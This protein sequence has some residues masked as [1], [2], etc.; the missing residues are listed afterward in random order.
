M[1]RSV[2][3]GAISASA[4]PWIRLK[5]ASSTWDGPKTSF[6]LLIVFLLILYTNLAVWYKE[7]DALRPALVIAVAAIVTLVVDLGQGRRAFRLSRPQGLV[8]L[9]FLAVCFISSFDAIYAR[10]AFERTSDVLK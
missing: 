8:L 6:K 9:A 3:F 2:Q 10:L 1:E 4:S 7:L 5:P